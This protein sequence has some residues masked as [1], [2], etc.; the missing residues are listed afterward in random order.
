MG[1]KKS[2]YRVVLQMQPN[3]YAW[4]TATGVDKV[5]LRWDAPTKG[6]HSYYAE[7]NLAFDTTT[8]AVWVVHLR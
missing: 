7:A 2:K 6:L 1:P 3:N 8:G 4:R 5:S